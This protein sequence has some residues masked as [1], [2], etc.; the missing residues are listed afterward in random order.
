VPGTKK[1]SEEKRNLESYFGGQKNVLKK[2]EKKEK[3]HFLTGITKKKPRAN[4]YSVSF[5]PSSRK[6]TRE[7]KS[8]Q[9]KQVFHFVP[10]SFFVPET[11]PGKKNFRKQFP[12]KKKKS[13]KC[14]QVFHFVPPSFFLQPSSGYA[15]GRVVRSIVEVDQSDLTLESDL[16]GVREGEEGERK[17]VEG[18]GRREKEERM[19]G[20]PRES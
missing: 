10:P 13:T 2:S 7:K 9:G 6:N 16:G 3:I 12:G 8:A 11:L 18:G 5:P 4:K 14:K 20:G 19:Y 15:P 1:Y 17:G